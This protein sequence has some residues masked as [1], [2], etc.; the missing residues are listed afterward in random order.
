MCLRHLTFRAATFNPRVTPLPPFQTVLDD[1]AGA[2]M[3]ILRGAV[4]RE[5]AEDCF[6]ETFLAALRAYPKLDDDRNLRGWLLTIAHRKAID[7]HRANGRRPIPVA[8]S[9]RGRRAERNP[10]ARRGALGG[11]RGAAAE[12]A[13]GGGAALRQRPPPRRDRRRARLLAGGR[14][15]QPARGTEATEKGTGMKTQATAQE[16]ARRRG[17]P[18]RV[19]STS[20]T[21]HRLALR[22]AAAGADA[23]GLVRVG[24]PNQDDDELLVDLA[25][26]VSPRVLEAPAELDEVRREL[27]LYFEGKLDDFDLPLDWR[28]SGGFRAACASDQP[29]PLRARP[30]ATPRSP[31]RPATSARCGR[32]ARACGSNPIPLVVPCHRVLRTGGALGGY[33]GGLPM[34][35]ALLGLEGACGPTGPPGGRTLWLCRLKQPVR[36]VDRPPDASATQTSAEV[37]KHGWTAGFAA[38]IGCW[39]RSGR[40]AAAPAAAMDALRC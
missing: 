15:P 10:G 22:A 26:R 5:G 36:T 27:D 24:L 2:V 38:A 14:P 18:K 12:A 8:E 4:G 21:R 17:P 19:C 16:T 11:G 35:Q 39:G 3:A 9:G 20:P 13:G 34:K 25:E 32:R 7:H 6:Q 28:L 1:H 31:A 40:A 30:A 33:G 29:H 37:K 23:A